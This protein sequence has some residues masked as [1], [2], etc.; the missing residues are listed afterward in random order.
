MT[1]CI[2]E[3]R[4]KDYSNPFRKIVYENQKE[5]DAVVGKLQEN[6]FIKLQE[7]ELKDFTKEVAALRKKFNLK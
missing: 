7:K 6:S 2:Y 3:S 4:A 1:K 5:M